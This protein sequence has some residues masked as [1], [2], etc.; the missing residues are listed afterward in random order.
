MAVAITILHHHTDAVN[1]HGKL[2]FR[3]KGYLA[4][5]KYLYLASRGQRAVFET[6]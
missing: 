1:G 5:S 4:I 2:V 6:S 3:L